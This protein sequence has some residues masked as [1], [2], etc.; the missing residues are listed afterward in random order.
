VKPIGGLIDGKVAE[1]LDALRTP[2]L[3]LVL[4]T[5]HGGAAAGSE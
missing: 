4:I 5:E 3:T 2:L 1:A